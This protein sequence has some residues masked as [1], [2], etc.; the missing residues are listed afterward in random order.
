MGNLLSTMRSLPTTGVVII[1]L[2]VWAAH[3]TAIGFLA[4]LYGDEFATWIDSRIDMLLNVLI[5]FMAF[6]NLY[7][8]PSLSEEPDEEPTKIAEIQLKPIPKFETYRGHRVYTEEEIQEECD[9][10]QTVTDRIP[11]TARMRVVDT[12]DRFIKII[13]VLNATE[14]TISCDQRHPTYRGVDVIYQV[15]N[16]KW[17]GLKEEKG[18]YRGHKIYS[19]E[20]IQELYD[21]YQKVWKTTAGCGIKV[22]DTNNKLVREMRIKGGRRF[23][24]ENDVANPDHFGSVI[25][26]DAE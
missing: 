19:R 18:K 15:R 1:G 7:V 24:L 23:E 9:K 4:T 21:E 3:T 2:G 22:V 8:K 14:F 6:V 13:T 11:I 26:V 10:V 16:D 17:E 5:I 25:Y 12:S 20:F